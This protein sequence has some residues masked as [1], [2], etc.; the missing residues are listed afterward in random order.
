MANKSPA[1]IQERAWCCSETK[2][3]V[4]LLDDGLCEGVRVAWASNGASIAKSIF[5]YNLISNE[6][7]GDYS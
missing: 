7:S 6:H 4:L 1:S 2:T 5:M 3:S